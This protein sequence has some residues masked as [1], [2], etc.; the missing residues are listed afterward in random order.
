MSEKISIVTILHGETEFIPL[1]LDNFQ[2]F[3]N[4]ENHSNYIQE[5]E[6]VIVD[7]GKEN[8]MNHFSK[9]KN[10]FSIG[11]QGQFYYG[12]IDQMIRFGLDTADK[13]IKQ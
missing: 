8:L 2:N 12:D 5:L 7:N 3:N 4:R 10:F 13:I 1:I 6:L 9:I 11:R